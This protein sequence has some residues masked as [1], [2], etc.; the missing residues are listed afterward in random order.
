MR[1]IARVIAPAGEFRVLA[2]EP[3]N[4]IVECASAAGSDR[5]I[6]EDRAMLKL[7]Q[8]GAAKIITV[9][10]FLPECGR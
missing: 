3:D 2:D 9:R 1:K 5:I 8:H 10:D 7:R 4:R 6:T